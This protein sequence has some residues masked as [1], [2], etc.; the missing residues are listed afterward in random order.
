[1]FK[2]ATPMEIV[3]YLVIV[4]VLLGFFQMVP[5]YVRTV[6]RWIWSRLKKDKVEELKKELGTQCMSEEECQRRLK[7]AVEESHD[8]LATKMEAGFNKVH[9]RIDDILRSGSKVKVA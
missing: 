9:E 3:Q 4:G 5:G 6:L 8:R 7:A 2:D 1:M